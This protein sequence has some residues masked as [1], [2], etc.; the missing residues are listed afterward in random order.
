M[1]FS[2][3]EFLL[4][5]AC[6]F[7]LYYAPFL[8][9]FQ[10]W[11]LIL[12]SL[13][14]YSYNNPVLVALLLFSIFINATSSYLVYYSNSLDKKLVA[15]VGVVANLVIIVFFKYSD[16]LTNSFG[17]N[18]SDIGQFLISLPLPLGIS[19]FTFEGITLL[20]DTYKGRNSE[21]YNSIIKKSFF[22]H[23]SNTILFVSFFPHLIA[24]PILKA[25]EFY[26]Q[27][28]NKRFAE[29][30]WDVAFK[31]LVTGYFLKNVIA[32][33]LKDHTFWIEYP[34]FLR[35]SSETLFIMLFGYSMQIFADFAG[36]SLIALGLATLL[37]YTLQGNFN[38]PYLSV[39]FS[40]FWRRWHISLSTFLK[41]YLYIPLGG[42]R[43]GRVRT[44][45][46]LFA[47]MALGGLWH[48]AAWSYA[49]W[50]MA[51]GLFLGLERLVNDYF[52]IKVGPFLYGVKWI[53]VFVFVTFAWLFFKLPEFSHV[54]EYMKAMINNLG[55]NSDIKK[56]VMILVYSLPV[57]VYHL[58]GWRR[59]RKLGSGLEKYQ[60][61][62]YGIMLFLLVLN[63]GS[64]ADFIYFQF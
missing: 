31:Q 49:I 64:T 51:H 11:A 37:G 47:T 61:V 19:F 54:V 40:E 42:N 13:V 16:M 52:E 15:T 44:Y 28:G 45:F 23:C 10:I 55:Y 3:P 14:F 48:G 57:V 9:S 59:E 35:E 17:L 18:H 27:I 8:K 58:I 7:I 4:L 6:T 46:N 21:H 1:L 26:P 22:E 20:V 32:D 62:L 30:N 2:S 50:G 24:G 60:Y 38:F 56:N 33:N 34:Y 39:S 29:I 53:M 43:Q 5:F 25:H 12:S 41:E 36:Y 63:C